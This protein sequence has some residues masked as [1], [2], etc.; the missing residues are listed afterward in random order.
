MV[1]KKLIRAKICS[2][3]SALRRYGAVALMI[4]LFLSYASP[5]ILAAPKTNTFAAAQQNT[6]NATSTSK[7]TVTLEPV[8]SDSAQ[9]RQIKQRLLTVVLIGGVLLLLLTFAYGY[10]RLELTTRGFYSGR[11]QI[12]SGI[13]SLATITGAYF[14]WRWIVNV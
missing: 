2:A 10:L 4:G 12:A 11:L 7:Q 14:L 13:A 9:E 6:P 8:E 1:F 3:S 5:T